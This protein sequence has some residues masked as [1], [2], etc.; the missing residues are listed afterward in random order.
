MQLVGVA[1][2]G[3][4]NVRKPQGVSS[5]KCVQVVRKIF[6]TRQVGHG[7]TLDPMATGVL[8]MALGKAT[9]FLQVSQLAYLTS[10]KEYTG[11]IRFGVITNSDDITGHATPWLTE[12]QVHTA[13]QRYIGDIDQ[14]PPRVSALKR[15][16]V[17]LYELAR[18]NQVEC[19]QVGLDGVALT[20]VDMKARKVHISDIEL[21]KFIPGSFPEADIR[22]VCGAGTYIRSI[23][24]ECGEALV[25]PP[26]YLHSTNVAARNSHGEFCAGGTL[27]SLER[28]R[29]GIFTLESSF[30]FEEIRDQLAVLLM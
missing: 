23:A 16:G 8:T 22:V 12:H 17:R 24:R 1:K 29:S 5:H 25:I 2:D 26:E 21:R 28:T 27:A 7:G 18:T 10:D 11:V 4:L 15:D 30:A 19:Q 14:V 3:F 20:D 13:L 9:K 6:H